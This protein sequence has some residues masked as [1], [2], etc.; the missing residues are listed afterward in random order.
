M[1]V[2]S[3]DI[4]SD[5]QLVVCQI[6]DEYQAREGKMAAYLHKAKKLLE[7][8][9]SYTISQIPRSQ[10]VE[11]NALT[12]LASKRDADQLKFIPV[13]TLNSPSIQTGEPLTVNCAIARD[14]WMTPVI[15]YL[16]DSV[17]PEEKKKARLLRLKAARYMLYDN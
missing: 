2:E 17:L 8:F 3:L 5:S 4:F 15:Q 14:N 12:L 7:S 1:K 11:A 9:N 13:E 6:N 16:K 10:N